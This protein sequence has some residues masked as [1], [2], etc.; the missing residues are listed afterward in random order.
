MNT[1]SSDKIILGM[2]G[3]REGISKQAKLVLEDFLFTNKDR[4]T[5]VHHGD[6]KGADSIF[7]DE[8]INHNENNPD[9]TIEI[10]IHPPSIKTMRNFNKG[11]NVVNLSPKPYLDRNKDIVNSSNMLIAF[12]SSHKEILRSGT[13]STIRYAN[14]KNL[15]LYIIYPNGSVN[16]VYPDDN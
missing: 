10:F 8:I 6:C 11:E 4:I 12:P 7:H 5:K 3:S 1:N 15:H 14:Q 16:E 2:T 9:N 13:W